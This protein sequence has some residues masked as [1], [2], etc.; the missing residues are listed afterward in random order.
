[1][2]TIVAQ[3][4]LSR[5]WSPRPT[6]EEV[7]SIR[8]PWSGFGLARKAVRE[9]GSSSGCTR[10]RYTSSGALVWGAL[11]QGARPSSLRI[12]H[13]TEYLPCGVICTCRQGSQE[14][15]KG[16]TGALPVRTSGYRTYQ[17]KA[18]HAVTS[19]KYQ[20]PAPL[21]GFAGLSVTE[22]ASKGTVPP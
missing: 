12:F 2:C 21:V 3:Q 14:G 11:Y 4:G 18:A 20:P 8:H 17:A 19:G 22:T 1:M 10:F 9:L 5:L 6:K 15:G 16:L 13:V 7:E